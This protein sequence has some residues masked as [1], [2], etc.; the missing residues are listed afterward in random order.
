M[1]DERTPTGAGPR[2][3]ARLLARQGVGYVVVGVVQLVVDWGVFVSAS[4]LGLP[5]A[6]ANLLGRASGAAL[7]FWLNGRYTFRDVHGRDRPGWSHGARF[8]AT[9]VVMTVLSTVCVAAVER[10]VGLQWAWI[11]KPVIELVLALFGFL[12]ARYWVFR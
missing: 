3:P 10:T 2:S 1:R 11:G 8:L 9:W 7:G 4:A 5:V 6:P 12:L